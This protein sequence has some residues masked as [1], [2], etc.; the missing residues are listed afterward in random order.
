MHLQ[1]PIYYIDD[2]GT[3][4]H[5]SLSFYIHQRTCLLRNCW[6]NLYVMLGFGGN[7]LFFIK[8][9]MLNCFNILTWITPHRKFVLGAE[10]GRRCPQCQPWRPSSPQ[11]DIRLGSV[12]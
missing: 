12:L 5:P 2:E 8:F 6:H 11:Y 7:I 9:W 4:Q 1:F 3:I 10:S